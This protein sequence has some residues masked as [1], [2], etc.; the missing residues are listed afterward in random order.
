[1]K[2]VEGQQSKHK[3]FNCKHGRRFLK[4]DIFPPE[5]ISYNMWQGLTPKPP[6][7]TWRLLYHITSGAQPKFRWVTLDSHLICVGFSTWQFILK[8]KRR[9]KVLPPMRKHLVHSKHP[10]MVSRRCCEPHISKGKGS[11]LSTASSGPGLYFKPYSKALESDWSRVQTI[12]K[13]EQEGR[14]R[15]WWN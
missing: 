5:S 1:M 13:A 3:I 8:C 6:S 4:L 9:A 12:G 7:H 15:K 14:L 11:K 10:H 2:R